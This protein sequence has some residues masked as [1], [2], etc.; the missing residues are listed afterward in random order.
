MHKFH[1][2]L[3]GSNTWLLSTEYEFLLLSYDS[4]TRYAAR[5]PNYLRNQFLKSAADSS[6]TDGSVKL[7]SLSKVA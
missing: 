1:Q 2:H 4:L 7:N 6:F 5:L 3:K